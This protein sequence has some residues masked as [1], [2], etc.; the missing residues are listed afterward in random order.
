MKLAKQCNHEQ[1]TKLK[2]IRASQGKAPF[3]GSQTNQRANTKTITTKHTARA[4]LSPTIYVS[5]AHDHVSNN[6]Y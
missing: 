4:T 1:H 2:I 3:I 6:M 5:L